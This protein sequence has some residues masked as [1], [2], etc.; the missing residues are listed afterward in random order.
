M[1]LRAESDADTE[2]LEKAFGVSVIVLKFFA[3]REFAEACLREMGH[4]QPLDQMA[5]RMLELL[6]VA[7]A[8]LATLGRDLGVE[9]VA[10]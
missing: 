6:P 10:G 5:A 7:M 1:C 9:W 4:A 8:Q 3:S 2:A